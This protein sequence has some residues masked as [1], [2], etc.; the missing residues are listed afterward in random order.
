MLLTREVGESLGTSSLS[1]RYEDECSSD[2]SSL[3]L[4]GGN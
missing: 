2:T 4:E 1:L 3:L